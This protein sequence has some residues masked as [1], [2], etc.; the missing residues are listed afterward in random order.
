MLSPAASKSPGGMSANMPPTSGEGRGSGQPAA[1]GAEPP[2][3]IERHVRRR[4]PNSTATIA[5]ART[6]ATRAIARG[7][8]SVSR[9]RT[10]L[11][12]GN[13]PFRYGRRLPEAAGVTVFSPRHQWLAVHETVF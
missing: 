4:G 12:R 1:G 6:A 9:V 8:G 5:K 10:L 3:T 2:G 11:L 13:H 7:C